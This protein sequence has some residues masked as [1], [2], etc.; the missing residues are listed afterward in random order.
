MSEKWRREHPEY[1]KKYHQEYY[2][3]NKEKKIAISVEW[4]KNNPQ[5][6]KEACKRYREKHP[7]KRLEQNRI[8][9]MK[10][11]EKRKAQDF[12]NNSIKRSKME[13]ASIC[14]RCGIQ[15]EIEAHHPDYSKA[16]YV[17]WLC[18]NCHEAEH[19]KK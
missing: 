13:R 1:M 3:K 19:S 17:I 9:R 5:A 14:S 8:W 4:A 15:G 7:A 16:D 18:K 10:N 2:Q 6:N 12:I 11:R